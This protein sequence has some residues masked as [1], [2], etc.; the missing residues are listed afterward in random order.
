[1]VSAKLVHLIE[2]HWESISARV[3]RRLRQQSGLP[4]VSS[5]PESETTAICQ[6]FLHNLGHW[7]VSSSEDEIAR[8]YEKIGS[9]RASQDIPLSECIR[10]VQIMKDATLDYVRDE[11]FVETSVDIYAEEELEI[12]LGHFFDLAIFYLARGHEAC[13]PHG[14]H[15]GV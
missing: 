12:Q 14:T 10:V 2:D 15:H 9:D 1:M 5:T 4:H 7:L 6:R 8:I 11:V 3:M 13:M